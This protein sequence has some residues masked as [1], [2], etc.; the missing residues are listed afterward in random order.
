M[1]N[2]FNKNLDEPLE[3]KKAGNHA[4][5]DYSNG[6]RY[7]GEIYDGMRHGFGTYYYLNGER[8]EGIWYKNMKHGRGTFFYKNGEVY[9]GFWHNNRKEGVG[10]YYHANGDRYYGEW[11]DNK[12]HGRGI[13]HYAEGG[14]F[15]GQFKNNKKNGLGENLKKDGNSNYEEWTDGKL[16]RHSEKFKQIPEV[17]S[18][19]D[20]NQFNTGKFEKYLESKTRQQ[21]ELKS[22]QIKSKYFTIEFAKKLKSKNP[23]NYYDSIRMLNSTNNFVFEKPEMN[24]WT[25]DDVA[26]VFKKIG[27]EKYSDKIKL[28]NF[29]GKKLILT[30]VQE[31]ASLLEITDINEIEHLQKSLA[32]LKKLNIQTEN[33]KSMHRNL[34]SIALKETQIQEVEE[35]KINKS[36]DISENEAEKEEGQLEDSRDCMKFEENK[37]ENVNQLYNDFASS[38]NIRLI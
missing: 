31:L 34:N 21:Y 7:R 4:I 15:V 11:R 28:K 26:D 36:E 19:I 12:K 32:T 10:T 2:Y 35:E 29:D 13:I 17:K 5:L 1:G 30:E 33:L 20:Y 23:E 27:Y 8:Y 16:I 14:K 3:K 22:N 24:Q 38:G 18:D 37:R 9:E 25:N 6:E